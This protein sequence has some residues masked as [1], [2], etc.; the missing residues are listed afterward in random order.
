MLDDKWRHELTLFQKLAI[1]L[2]TIFGRYPAVGVSKRH[3]G[4]GK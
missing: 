3:I 4:L 2:G 1:D